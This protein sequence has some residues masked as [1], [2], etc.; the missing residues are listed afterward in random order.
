M[1]MAAQAMA[2][3]ASDV[4]EGMLLGSWRAATAPRK[5]SR[6]VRALQLAGLH[7]R[8]LNGLHA[9]AQR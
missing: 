6:R 9:A 1:T 4:P 8:P 5:R 2:Y 3:I 7:M